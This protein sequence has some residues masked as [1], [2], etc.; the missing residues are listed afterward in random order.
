M[1]GNEPGVRVLC[2]P[3]EYVDNS[4]VRTLKG[5]RGLLA[6]SPDILICDIA[7]P[8]E[9]GYVLL[10]KLREMEKDQERRRMP[11][12]AL[13]AYAREEDRKRALEAGFETHLSKP[14]ESEQLI[15]AILALR[16]NTRQAYPE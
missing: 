9:N 16:P 5:C 4:G 7:M 10:E 15:A 3:L 11:A 8:E 6:N 1:L 12:I 2:V 13:T 14:V